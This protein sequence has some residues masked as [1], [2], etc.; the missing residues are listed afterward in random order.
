MAGSAQLWPGPRM[1][2]FLRSILAEEP[3]VDAETADRLSQRLTKRVAR[4]LVWDSSGADASELAAGSIAT[5]GPQDRS[6]SRPS[7]QSEATAA[8]AAPA[9]AAEAFDPFAFSIVVVLKRQGRAALMQ[10]LEAISS[11]NHL[12]TMAAAQHISID[13]TITAPKKLREAI[14][15]GA[16]QRLADRRAAAS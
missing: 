3:G 6:E 13:K 12:R 1:R 14:V 10:R 8:T 2:A 15:A 11:P 4:M 9:D 7:H 16:E 5:A